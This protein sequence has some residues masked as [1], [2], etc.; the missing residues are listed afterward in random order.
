MDRIVRQYCAQVGKH[1]QCMPQTK[2][3]LLAGLQEELEQLPEEC[4]SSLSALETNY[5]SVIH[6]A[7]E[8]QEAVK[9][10]EQKM[11][12]RRKMRRTSLGVTAAILIVAVS[13]VLAC[14]FSNLYWEL[15]EKVA[16]VPVMVEY[17]IYDDAES[18]YRYSVDLYP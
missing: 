7:I 1:L 10:E 4:R 6:T 18:T 5:R 16:P 8:L 11:A 9:P 15:R 3:F 12:S 2:K 17:E 13:A 14:K